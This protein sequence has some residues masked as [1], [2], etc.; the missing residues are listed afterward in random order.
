MSGRIR[1]RRGDDE[2]GVIVIMWALLMVAVLIVAALV[3]DLGQLKTTRRS[4]QSVADLAALAGGKSLS[5]GAPQA[6]CGDALKYLK[7]NTPD[8]PAS[9]DPASNTCSNIQSLASCKAS[10]TPT[11]AGFIGATGAYTVVIR[12]P[13]ADNDSAMTDGFRALNASI[14]GTPCERMAVTIARSR[15]TFFG[16]VVGVS[17]LTTHATAVVRASALKKKG[18]PALWLLE[19][20]NCAALK[21]S[22]SG[23]A[24]N[25]GDLTVDPIVP[26]Y[27]SI[28]S[29]G[30][31]CSGGATTLS[32]PTGSLI[33]APT[34]GSTPG[35]ISLFAMPFL[36]ACSGATL[37]DCDPS[38]VQ[39]NR[40]LPQPRPS[41]ERATRAPVD[42]TFN[43]KASYP[44]YK[45]GTVA[46]P[47]ESCPSTGDGAHFP[48]I[49]NLVAAIGNTTGSAPA[50]GAWQRWTTGG[51]GHSCNPSGNTTV[52][53]NWWVD[54]STLSVG[55][56]ATVT[57]A[58][59]N[60]VM[61][62]H[63]KLTGSGA[64]SMNTANAVAT[65]PASC[66]PP[67]VA[68]P[69]VNNASTNAA[70][71]Y[72]R[73]GDLNLNGGG[74]NFNRV[75]VYQANGVLGNTGGSPPTWSAP[76]EG[77]FAYLALW[78]EKQST[79]YQINGGA[80][81]ALQG[82]YFTPYGD[83]SLAGGSPVAQQHAQFISRSLAVS[84]GATFN[85]APDGNNFI[86][87]PPK[88]G[89]LIR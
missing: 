14:D 35:L 8:L 28:D 73:N 57:F 31:G 13:V 72:M 51:G 43:C 67:T 88:A 33:A 4:G 47:I 68:T 32:V 44:N 65:L 85:L 86:S 36:T 62:G 52:T 9:A 19:P 21:V 64:V 84:G 10:P 56:G 48:Y 18:I 1:R 15:P 55:G 34:S 71:L 24:V 22:G 83:M 40:L 20:A 79:A 60:V 39:A 3:I 17:S 27:V 2:R 6:A 7:G 11:D 26:G 12:Y 30:S 89:T 29:D 50:T 5:S 42:W 49:D 78:S 81:M 45:P 37:H 80:S 16:G 82:I 76:T 74:I 66:L 41:G 46:V 77:P 54:C 25:V 23:T 63:L 38:D 53:G 59:G 58:N 61:D 70:F 75:F 69:C 87:I